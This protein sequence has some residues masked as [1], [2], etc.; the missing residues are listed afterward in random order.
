MA[1]PRA[2]NLFNGDAR[3]EQ[4]IMSKHQSTVLMTPLE[5]QLDAELKA[6]KLQLDKL[7]LDLF[8]LRRRE[9]AK[10][11]ATEFGVDLVKSL[12]MMPKEK[13]PLLAQLAEGNIV[14]LSN[15]KNLI[16]SHA[17]FMAINETL[18]SDQG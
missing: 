10:L 3:M 14:R 17:A 7:E 12:Q 1:Q 2:I 16:E 18:T 15:E 5:I 6:A 11:F 4:L 13:W 9:K 8:V